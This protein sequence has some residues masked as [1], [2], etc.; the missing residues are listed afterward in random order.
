MK[1]I[2]INTKGFNMKK[3]MYVTMLF[4]SLTL[5][6]NSI[7]SIPA[8]NEDGSAQIVKNQKL[9][10]Q[11]VTIIYED[12]FTGPKK[13]QKDYIQAFG[14]IIAI[15]DVYGSY[16]HPTQVVLEGYYC[17]KSEFSETIKEAIAAKQKVII[18]RRHLSGRLHTILLTKCIVLKP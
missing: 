12:N 11:L 15:Q 7:I 14:G 4:S 5:F 1:N 18:I 10:N 16:G 13:G 3:F 2:N 8:P 9:F 17:N 6:G